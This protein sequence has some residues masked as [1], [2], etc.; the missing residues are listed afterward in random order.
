VGVGGHINPCD[1]LE[2]NSNEDLFTAACRRELHEEMILPDCDLPLT[3]LGILNDDRTEVGS[4]HLG[5]V[6]RLDAS[7]FDVA[8]READAMEGGFENISTLQSMISSDQDPFETWSSLLI[9]SGVLTPAAS[10]LS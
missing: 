6:Y 3:P 9:R 10:N 2:S 4:V 7:D 8:I 1:Q 5:L